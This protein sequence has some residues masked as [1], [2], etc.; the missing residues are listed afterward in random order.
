MD[1]QRQNEQLQTIYNG[2]VPIQDI[3]LKTSQVEWTIETDG[4]SGLVRSVQVPRSDE[5]EHH[6]RLYDSV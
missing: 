6:L 3:A 5:D 1:E 2:S 4:E